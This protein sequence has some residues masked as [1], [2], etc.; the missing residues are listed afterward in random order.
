MEKSG[1]TRERCT[2]SV[3]IDV[4]ARV[5]DEGGFEEVKDHSVPAAVI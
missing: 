1:D 4:N 2:R 5:A 3:R